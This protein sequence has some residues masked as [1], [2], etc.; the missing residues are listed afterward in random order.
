MDTPRA[1]TAYHG[2]AHGTLRSP[3]S[4]M[5]P[6]FSPNF[7]GGVTAVFPYLQT[8]ARRFLVEAFPL[9]RDTR[10]Q[11]RLAA[12]RLCLRPPILDPSATQGFPASPRA[13]NPRAARNAPGCRAN[14]GQKPGEFNPPIAWRRRRA[15]ASN[16]WAHSAGHAHTQPGAGVGAGFV[17]SGPEF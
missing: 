13:P 7:V 8:T 3:R 6:V 14:M 12:V 17:C 9:K 11:A 1:G 5:R 2:P 10:T 4:E 16:R 15:A